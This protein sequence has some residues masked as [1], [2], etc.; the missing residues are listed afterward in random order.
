MKFA[1][2]STPLLVV[3]LAISLYFIISLITSLTPDSS[4]RSMNKWIDILL[5][6]TF[7]LLA[8]SC[9]A[10]LSFEVARA[11][12]DKIAVRKSLILIGTLGAVFLISFLIAD[13]EMPRFNGVEKFIASGILTPTVSHCIETCLFTSYI[14]IVIALIGIVYSYIYQFFN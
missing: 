6:W 3:I 8:I 11:V 1:K 13:N 5:S 7:I 9:I 12:S 4:D 10:V 14:L 2:V